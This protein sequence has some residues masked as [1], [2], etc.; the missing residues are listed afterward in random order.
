MRAVFCGCHSIAYPVRFRARE[1]CKPTLNNEQI[2][3]EKLIVGFIALSR[4]RRLSAAATAQYR[5]GLDLDL[6]AHAVAAGRLQL[7]PLADVLGLWR[8]GDRTVRAMG[9]RLD[10]A[11][12]AIALSA[13]GDVRDR[14]RTADETAGRAMVSAVAIRALA[15]RQR[16]VKPASAAPLPSDF[17]IAA[18]PEPGP[19]RRIGLMLP[20]GGHRQ[21]AGESITTATTTMI[22]ARSI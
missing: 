5:T 12:A 22:P 2:A 4:L 15:R 14:Q 1:L 11:G 9:W 17:S 16:A 7:P 18:A 13:L 8:R 20:S 19:E 10:D 3:H 21:C 6:P